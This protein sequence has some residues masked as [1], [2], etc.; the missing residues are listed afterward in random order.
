MIT[1]DD[2]CNIYLYAYVWHRIVNKVW[3]GNRCLL[4]CIR[5]LAFCP[6]TSLQLVHFSVGLPV[7]LPS[8][9]LIK[10]SRNP[11]LLP[12]FSIHG[13]KQL[14]HHTRFPCGMENILKLYN[15][16]HLEI[17][18]ERW[19]RCRDWREI[20]NALP[21]VPQAEEEFCAHVPG[22]CRMPHLVRLQWCWCFLTIFL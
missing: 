11:P 15:L 9:Q 21:S 18:V 12:D 22:S 7:A 13:R 1:L 4:F 3:D 5:F 16:A 6:F 17:Q 14:Q 10:W 8:L 20:E 19:E 2:E